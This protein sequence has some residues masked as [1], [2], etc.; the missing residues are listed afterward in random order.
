MSIEIRIFTNPE[1]GTDARQVD[2]A[3]AALGYVRGGPGTSI[4][5]PGP[6]GSGMQIGGDAAQTYVGDTEVQTGSA[7]AG[8]TDTTP[9]R[10]RGEASPGKTRRTKAEIAEDEAADAADAATV[11]QDKADEKAEVEA[12]R[13][14]DKPVTIDDV[15]NIVNEYVTKFGLPA[16]QEDGPKIFVEALG[17]PPE[18]ENFW[19]FSILPTDQESIAKV[20]AV[21]TRAVAEN[22]LKRKAV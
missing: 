16:T 7:S 6:S 10:K 14:D 15:K 2:E 4:P 18:G 9:I 8:A 1:Y 13:G 11:K 17:Q 12:N 21:W 3:M 22:P 5:L 19:R 20:A